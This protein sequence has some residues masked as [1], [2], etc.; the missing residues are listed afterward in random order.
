MST[1]A[2]TVTCFIFCIIVS[3]QG[4]AYLTLN[5]WFL[6]KSSKT[7]PL[8]LSAL[9]MEHPLVIKETRLEM[10]RL[11]VTENPIES[12]ITKNTGNT[13]WFHIVDCDVVN[14]GPLANSVFKSAHRNPPDICC[15]SFYVLI[16]LNDCEKVFGI[17][18]HLWDIAQRKNQL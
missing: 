15:L 10:G 4:M 14:Y 2:S 9:L 6:Q 11:K 8:C 12:G 13:V 18:S 17:N 1:L 3:K 5:F 16:G 7:H